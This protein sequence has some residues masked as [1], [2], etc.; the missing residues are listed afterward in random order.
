MEVGELKKTDILGA[1][2]KKN[3][4]CSALELDVPLQRL[5][6]P[7]WNRDQILFLK[8][9]QRKA[10]IGSFSIRIGSWSHYPGDPGMTYHVAF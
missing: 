5:Q 9:I 2:K 4:R 3:S 8:R 6:G 10:G 1:E 7:R